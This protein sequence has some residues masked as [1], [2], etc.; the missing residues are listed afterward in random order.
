MNFHFRFTWRIRLSDW[1]NFSFQRI[2]AVEQSEHTDYRSLPVS[3]ATVKVTG[4]RNLRCSKAKLQHVD[5]MT[6]RDN[7]GT[8]VEAVGKGNW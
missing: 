6:S 1:T 2:L 4:Q 7:S 3:L 8:A 5:E